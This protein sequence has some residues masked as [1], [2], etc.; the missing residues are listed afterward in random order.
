M[1]IT[2]RGFIR[3][4]VVAFAAWLVVGT[5]LWVL[6]GPT[7]GASMAA[8]AATIL[9]A[10]GVW[11]LTDR[12]PFGA[13]SWLVLTGV[14]AVV[15]IC[16][17]AAMMALSYGVAA[18]LSDAT[19]VQTLAGAN[20]P[21]SEFVFWIWLY[22]VILVGS[23]GVRIRDSMQKDREASARAEARLAEA[24]LASLQG[25]LNPHFLFNA[26][27]SV[28]ALVAVDPPR[29]EEALQRL[30][31][32]LRFSLA[33]VSD[34]T[35]GMDEELAF[36]KAY[37]ELVELALG[38]RLRLSIAVED[39][40]LEASVPPFS[41]QVLTENAVR[42]G[43]APLVGG[44]SITIEVGALSAHGPGAVDGTNA[45]GMNAAEAVPGTGV[46]MTVINDCG[47]APVGAHHSGVGLPN[48]RAR[49]EALYGSEAELTTQTDGRR[50]TASI[51]IPSGKDS[52]N[53]GGR[54]DS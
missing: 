34:G 22:G 20:A 4:A 26:L 11:W 45:D 6:G 43:I 50:F 37:L 23:Y 41:L 51:R 14:N 29:A 24:R 3:L 19:L 42:H 16:F 25:Q 53:R 18:V 15:A 2:A 21:G 12:L 40:A 49:L 28:R 33:D 27:H 36:T 13:T 44:G 32:L 1:D 9:V 5:A 54:S 48:L 10:A 8:V 46:L 35:T 52:P 47:S 38:D 31:E 30:A 39:E 7:E 17:A